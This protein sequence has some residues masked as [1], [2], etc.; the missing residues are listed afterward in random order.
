MFAVHTTEST[1]SDHVRPERVLQLQI[2]A[3]MIAIDHDRAIVTMEAWAKFID[4]ASRTRVEPFDT[5]EE[6]LPNRAIDAGEL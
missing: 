2:F 5:L 3:E 1:N 6:Y 4:L